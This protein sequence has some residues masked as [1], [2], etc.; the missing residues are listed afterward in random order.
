MRTDVPIEQTVL[1][2]LQCQ[3]EALRFTLVRPPMLG[4]PSGKPA[5][6]EQTCAD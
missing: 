1:T 5:R 4:E 6:A 3:G 2:A